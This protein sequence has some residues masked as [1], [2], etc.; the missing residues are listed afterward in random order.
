MALV[1]TLV[2]ASI[3]NGST[4]TMAI[5]FPAAKTGT[6]LALA[7]SQPV[8]LYVLLQVARGRADALSWA[9]AVGLTR[10]G[11]P[12]FPT[13]AKL[14]QLR[15][16]VFGTALPCGAATR[17]VSSAPQA[18]PQAGNNE[19]QMLVP[20]GYNN[21][22]SKT[23]AHL[24]PPWELFLGTALQAGVSRQQ[25][26]Q[27][28]GLHYDSSTVLAAEAATAPAAEAAAEAARKLRFAVAG[29]LQKL[30]PIQQTMLVST[31]TSSIGSNGLIGHASATG[32]SY[33]T[34][35]AVAGPAES[36]H[37]ASVAQHPS[38]PAAPGSVSGS[39]EGRG[40]SGDWQLLVA[41]LGISDAA[42]L[43]QLAVAPCLEVPL[44]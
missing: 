7:R 22:L 28:Q 8:C 32:S 16:Q 9:E 42:E 43:Q 5:R 29:G 18:L 35:A 3:M 21:S 13:A 31:S 33:A 14:D 38:V 17:S 39:S 20:E 37:C 44:R 1:F 30:Q 34:T 36:I 15:Q 26:L 2:T 27:Q 25:Q 40:S 24:T 23:G 10:N 41:E 11:V 6:V 19:P 12:V 4:A